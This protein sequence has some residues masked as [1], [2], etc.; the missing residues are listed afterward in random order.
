MINVCH[1]VSGDLW[2]GAEAMVVQLLR[3]L[4]RYD[5]LEV[6][7]I[8]FNEGHLADQ[9]RTLGVTTHVIPEKS[10]TNAQMIRA[11]RCIFGKEHV[12]IAHSHG[13]KENIIAYLASR[14]KRDVRL[15]GTQHGMPEIH[16]KKATL[17]HR[18]TMNANFM[19]LAKCFQHIVAV[20]E[21]MHTQLVQQYGFP[22]EKLT[23]IHNGISITEPCPG[24]NGKKDFVI[25]SSGRLFPVKDYDLMVEIARKVLSHSDRISFVLAGDGPEQGRIREKIRK[26]GLEKSFILRGFVPDVTEFYQ[27]LDL[28]LNTSVH[29]GIPLSVLEAMSYGLPVIAPK[30]GGLAEIVENGVDGYLVEGRRPDEYAQRCI[31]LHRDDGLRKD[32]G[33]AARRKICSQFSSDQMAVSYYRLYTSV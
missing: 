28:Y 2:A 21:D 19:V 20:S 33:S 6:S 32:I 26:Y 8:L 11:V 4:V 13:Y 29:E 24:S 30:V 7:A 31:T 14:S 15:V 27:S 23:V 12:R 3:L 5:D 10:S 18:I 22:E 16:V 1:I 9:C 17:K 25:G